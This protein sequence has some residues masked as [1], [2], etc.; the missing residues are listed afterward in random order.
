MLH[1]L[2]L[3]APGSESCLC[4]D[5]AL[6]NE[7]IVDP[8]VVEDDEDDPLETQKSAQERCVT[9]DNSVQ[10]F[11][12]RIICRQLNRFRLRSLHLLLVLLFQL[13]ED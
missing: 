8:E 6:L 11:K 5:V 2:L 13:L 10:L 4:A 7:D 9:A 1:L 12:S 3:Q